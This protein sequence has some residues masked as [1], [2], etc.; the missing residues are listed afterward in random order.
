MYIY[1]CVGFYIQVSVYAAHLSVTLLMSSQAK[2]APRW[3]RKRSLYIYGALGSCTRWYWLGATAAAFDKAERTTLNMHEPSSSSC[4][5]I[6]EIL[7]N[8]YIDLIEREINISRIYTH[9]HLL[10]VLRSWAA[11]SCDHLFQSPLPTLD[12]LYILCLF[13][14]S[15]HRPNCLHRA[16][17]V[18]SSTDSDEKKKN[19]AK[20]CVFPP[21]KEEEE[22]SKCS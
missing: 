13:H 22:L 5:H 16:T 7:L 4:A 17:I 20:K 21:Q 11:M 8:L 9:T 1:T 6:D 2:V 19:L 18:R 12:I 15:A 3:K 14:D 10:M